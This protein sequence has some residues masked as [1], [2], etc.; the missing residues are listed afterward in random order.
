MLLS[1]Q[2]VALPSF[3][4]NAFEELCKI[5]VSY[6]CKKWLPEPGNFMY[7]R[8]TLIGTGR[9][10]GMQKPTEAMFFILLSDMK[11]LDGPMKL[12]ASKEDTIRAWPGG[13]GYAKVGA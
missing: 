2:R 13:F 6:E 10:V 9:S 4:P 5:L 3:S 8:P 7:L 1:S 12:L 11:K